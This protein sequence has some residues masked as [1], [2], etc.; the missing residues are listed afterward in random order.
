MAL[1]VVFMG[2]P[3]FAV[4]CLTRLIAD[5]HRIAGVFTQPDRPRGRGLATAPPPVKALA[6]AH[7][8]SVYQPAKLRDG[9]A[10]RL[11]RA[12]G[13]DLAVVAAY[14]RILPGELLAVPPLGCINVHASLLPAWRG[15][16]PIQW[17]VMA[18]ERK[19]GVTIMQMDAGLD[20]GDIL[21]QRETPI[22]PEETAGELFGRL[23]VLGAQAL[24]E[25]VRLLETGQAVRIRQDESL[26][27]YAPPI[28]RELAHL[29]FEKPAREIV[30]RVRGLYPS[31]GAFTLLG[32]RVLKVHKAVPAPGL[33][34]RPGLLLD[35]K[36]LLVG[37]ADGAVEL[38]RIQPQG[39]KAM[40]G[41]AF[42]NGLRPAGGEMFT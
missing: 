37:C 29:D 18:G 10:L 22:G 3:E 40:E 33:S 27:T 26:A 15:A 41:A 42:V 24:S 5:G 19:T 6:L 32:G 31:P 36:R 2:T 17:S 11:L 35:K 20:T 39:K 16:A 30:D 23:S 4:P 12:L 8:L 38:L 28:G 14:G 25:A 7:G 9:Q 34:G 1:N 13:P 21:L